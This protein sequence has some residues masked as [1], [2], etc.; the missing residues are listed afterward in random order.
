WA[1][2]L[3][4]PDTTWSTLTGTSVD[5]LGPDTVVGVVQFDVGPVGRSLLNLGTVIGAL[6]VLLVGRGWRLG[7]AARAWSVTLVGWGLV[8]AAGRGWLPVASPAPEVL[9]AP[10][11]VMI[12]LAIGLGAAAFDFD[13]R[14]RGFSWRQLTGVI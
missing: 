10:A 5:A 2:E 9:L 4:S 8:L 7:W 6:Y 12:S 3:L 1:L 14:R 11:G 13:V